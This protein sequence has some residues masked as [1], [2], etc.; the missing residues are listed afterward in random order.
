MTTEEFI[1]K[2]RAIHGAKY[3]YSKVEYVG[4]D[5]KVCII[6][7]KHGEF[8]KTFH[9]HLR[10]QGCPI[11]KRE[12]K[13]RSFSFVEKAKIV[14][15][16]EYNYEKANFV[17][18]RTKV[19]IICPKHGEFWQNP[20][21]HLQGSKCPICAGRKSFGKEE[22]IERAQKTHG[23]FYDY[24]KVQYVNL[25]T[26]V[27][28]VCPKHGEFWQVASCHILGY[29]C[30]QC[31]RE[32]SRKEPKFNTETFIKEAKKV[33]GSDYCYEKTQY[34]NMS[35]K[36]CVTCPIH[37]DF[38]VLPYVHLKGH[39][40]RQCAPLTN[41][42]YT[43][44][45]CIEKALLCDSRHE[46]EVKYNGFYNSARV[47]GWYEDCV[48]HMASKS[49]KEKRCIYVYKFDN[50]DGNNYAYVGLTYNMNVRDRRHH[51]EGSVF[52]FA[53]VHQIAIPKPILLTDYL[54]EQEA[55]SQEG[56]WLDYYIRKG[57]IA[58]NRIKTG[59]LGGQDKLDYSL[60]TIEN[61]LKA[62][63][64]FTTWR[65]EYKS[66]NLYLRQKKMTEIIDKYFP[67][68]IR[69]IYDDYENCK[70]A[71]EKCDGAEELHNKYPGAIAAAKRHGWYEAFT[72]ILYDNKIKHERE[73]FTT[74]ITQYEKLKDFR[75]NCPKEYQLIKKRKW[76]N[77]LNPLIRE[78]HAHYHFTDEEIKNICSAYK[79]RAELK[80]HHP[81]I[82]G[83]CDH[84]KIDLFQLNG[85]KSTQKKGVRLIRDGRVVAEFEM[86]KEA[87]LFVGVDFR[88]IGR[89]LNKGEI[90]H[91]YVWESI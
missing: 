89:Y 47:N 18:V 82:I 52:N 90:Y 3:D 17:N 60:E 13:S 14:H 42:K 76:Y 68:R 23:N 72:H 32:K 22:F 79:S 11:C 74:L 78:V 40:C 48:A 83:Y 81:E 67:N 43:K 28:I 87:C 80:R 1:T 7:P 5:K 71:Y 41:R 15:G 88:N 70:K 91:G 86:Q 31:A 10:G 26:K 27:C 39:K 62:C 30:P 16:D 75:K 45:A 34:V 65:K 66:Y 37:G 53:T 2:A 85:W 29:R 73:K 51:K 35:T 24:S 19:C 56:V 63:N 69:R 54:D 50:I 36:V 57:Y 33:H 55:S 77:L 25:Q 38:W 8:Y 49:I 46:F 59:S 44:E 20:K 58:L 6:C 61:T 64:S 21:S 12:E 4:H 84:H 9:N